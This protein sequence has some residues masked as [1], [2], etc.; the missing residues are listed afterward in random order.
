[1]VEWFSLGVKLDIPPGK[2]EEIR[3]NPTLCGIQQ[4]RMEMFCEWIK[5]QLEPS[6]SHVVNALMKIGR[7]SLAHK[8]ALKYGKRYKIIFILYRVLCCKSFLDLVPDPTD[9]V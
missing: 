3:H 9:W 2:L 5:R 4:F 6:W 8:V 1:M 7:A